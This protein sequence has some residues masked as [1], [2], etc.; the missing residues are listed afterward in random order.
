MK[1]LARLRRA[2]AVDQI[3]LAR[4]GMRAVHLHGTCPTAGN[5]LGDRESILGVPNRGRQKFRERLGAELFAHRVPAGGHAGHR[6]RVDAALRHL[7]DALRGQEVD[8]QAGRRPS[9]RVEAVDGVRLGFVINDEEVAAQPVAGR[10]HQSDGGVGRNRRVDGVAAALENLHA[11]ARR[12]R[13]ARRD[14]AEG[15]GDDRA[16]HHGPGRAG[17]RLLRHG[18][19]RVTRARERGKKK[20]DGE[21]PNVH[22]CLQRSNSTPDQRESI[23][24][25]RAF[26][27]YSGACATTTSA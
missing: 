14:D 2:L 21:G 5:P 6:H 4:V 11:G 23:A 27:V 1:H 9:A 25:C 15:G 20:S 18:W 13:L 8:G 17:G 22:G 26:G 16:A 10:L 19:R 24:P 7:L 12:Q 3:R